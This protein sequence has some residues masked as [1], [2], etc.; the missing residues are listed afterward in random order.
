[1][2]F[3]DMIRAGGSRASP[4][5]SRSS[6]KRPSR[7]K[8]L[9]AAE[10]AKVQ[11]ARES[12]AGAIKRG[13][14]EEHFASG[15]STDQ[16]SLSDKL[17]SHRAGTLY[18]Y[19]VIT[20]A[21]SSERS[22]MFSR[23][24][25]YRPAGN[26][27]NITLND[28]P[29]IRMVDDMVDFSIS[30]AMTGLPKE[31]MHDYI[32][33]DAILVHFIPLD[34]FVNDKSVVT[35]QINDFRHITNTVVRSCK[36]DNTMGYNILFTLDY[37]I[38]MRDIDNLTLSFSCPQKD[39]QSGVA[40]GAV[41]A[42]VQMQSM[43]TPRRFPL[44]ETAGVTLFSDTDLDE[45]QY[46]PRTLDM[47]LTPNALAGSRE[48]YRRGEIENLTLPKSDKTELVTARTVLGEM[49]DVEEVGSVVEKMKA[50]ATLKQRAEAAQVANRA[51]L[52]SLREQE[53][54]SE[55]RV[56]LT[57]SHSGGT[58][59]GHS[60]DHKGPVSPAVSLGPDDSMS[61]Q[62]DTLSDVNDAF[63]GATGRKVVKFSG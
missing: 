47:V 21:P 54:S 6:G 7:S 61:M 36:I 43:T 5:N 11:N 16:P 60:S 32:F 59:G 38:E 25:S 35:V 14:D 45:Y 53:E 2:G 28:L 33:L 51:K 40:W 22:T 42:V 31:E 3:M 9:R 49:D 57:S 24:R 17:K 10:E 1:M 44:V 19:G 50:M 23:L 8:G 52:Q 48:A 39:F 20:N 4:G 12:R 18:K 37:C 56:G 46:D 27:R 26:V 62:G 13:M 63:D 34:S 29:L 30:S 41:K 58:G 55:T 15:I